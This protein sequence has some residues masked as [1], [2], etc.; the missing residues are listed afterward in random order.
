M[1]DKISKMINLLPP[2]LETII[3]LEKFRQSKEQ[4]PE[5]LLKI[6]E[7]D[8]LLVAILLKLSNSVLYGFRNSVDTASKA[9][10]LLGI[11]FTL[12]L[13]FGYAIK[14]TLDTNLKAYGISSHEF[15]KIANISSI[16]TNQWISKIDFDLKE[17]LILPVFLQNIGMFILSNLATEQDKIDQFYTEIKSGRDIAEVEM[18]FFGT[19]TSKVTA[20]IFRHWNLN[21]K[22]INMIEFVDDLN[23]CPDEYKCEEQI[24][25]VVKTACNILN[26]LD[27]KSV[28]EAIEKAKL[29]NLDTTLLSESIKKVQDRY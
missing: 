4:E 14:Q 3:E 13:A 1:Q 27:E 18:M 29:F 24:L 5:I 12:S 6:I 2:L 15:M 20:N 11:N 8:P 21:D 7:K 10:N 23:N 22:L 26:P 16:I 25:N 17:K 28:S 19:T 9:L